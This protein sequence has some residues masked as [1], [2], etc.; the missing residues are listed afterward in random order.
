M[1]EHTNIFETMIVLFVVA[2][3][4]FLYWTKTIVHKNGFKT[5]MFIGFRRDIENL[6][7]I[8]EREKDIKIK[9]KYEKIL[10]GFNTSFIATI[11]SIFL[12]LIFEIII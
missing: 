6:R 11:G 7:K 12:M 8:I 4:A 1:Y 3:N 2:T 5:N 9:N 10:F